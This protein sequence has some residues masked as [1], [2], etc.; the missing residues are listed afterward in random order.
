MWGGTL[1]S[2]TAEAR[3]NG[4]QDKPSQVILAHTNVLVN[5]L[6]VADGGNSLA[7]LIL[8]GPSLTVS[9]TMD[10][11]KYNGSDGRFVVKSGHLFAGMIF[12]A[13]GGGPDQRGRGTIEIQG[14]TVVTKDIALGNSSGGHS[15]LHIVGSKASGIAVEDYLSIGVY[16]YLDL[17]KE[18]PPSATEL[19]FDIDADGVTPIFTWGKTEGRVNFPVPDNKG[20]GLGTCRLVL[21]LLA[22]PPSG[23]I[24]LMGCANPCHG[25]FSDLAEGAT[26]RAEFEGKAYDWKLTYHGGRTKCDIML[27]RPRIAAAD[28]RMVPYVTGSKAKS[29]QFDRAVVESA[30]REFY[31]QV[32]AQQTPIGGGPLAFPGAEGYGA[33]AKGGR[34]GEVLF[35]TNLSDSGPGSLRAAVEAKG[36]R[37][38]IFR[39]GGVIETKGL[40]I[41][42]PY[43]TIAGQ[44]APGDGI[45]IRKTESSGEA[46]A[47]SATHDVIIR[48]LRIRAGNNSGQ[49][50]SESFHAY[51]SDNFIV[52]HCSCSWGTPQTLT[53]S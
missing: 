3:I 21:H 37:T 46:F 13:G 40:E 43:I 2:R 5:H 4:T 29:F 41:R 53:T 1:P 47:V 15:T 35:V 6:S 51:G 8:D 18:P 16:N 24:L 36:P 28:G 7:S 19:V 20:N 52:D 14:G 39:V 22:A 50:R 31:R 44:T 34:G 17:E 12:V 23:D 27:T 48:F 30:Y 33:Y 38:V 11:G 9:G 49:F 10:V 25:A 32:D 42:E 26:V 45:C